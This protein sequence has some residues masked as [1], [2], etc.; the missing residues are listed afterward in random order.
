MVFCKSCGAEVPEG[1]KF[2]QACGA[3]VEEPTIIYN[4]AAQNTSNSASN[5]KLMGILSYIGILFIVPLLATK[6]SKFARFHANQGLVLFITDIVLFTVAGIIDGFV[7]IIGALVSWA[8]Y[9]FV[10]VLMILGIVNAANGE[11]KELPVIGQYRL[12]K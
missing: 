2:C 8:V 4:G 3:P 6:E 7:P 10:L 9:V 11:E 12:I 1:T 5:D